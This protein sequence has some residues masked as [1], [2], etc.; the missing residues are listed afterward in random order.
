V[1]LLVLSY[2][3]LLTLASTLWPGE[4]F[5]SNSKVSRIMILFKCV[6]ILLN[7][8]RFSIMI[9]FRSIIPIIEEIS[10]EEC[11]SAD[12]FVVSAKFLSKTYSSL[13]LSKDSLLVTMQSCRIL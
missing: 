4:V 3:H 1:R 11:Y 5:E 7:V 10:T 9:Q 13:K 6:S 8:S 2:M 12:V